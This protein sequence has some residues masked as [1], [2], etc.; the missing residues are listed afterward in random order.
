LLAIVLEECA[1]STS[2]TDPNSA[3]PPT[4]ADAAEPAVD[5]SPDDRVVDPSA[6]VNPDVPDEAAE[7]LPRPPRKSRK[8]LVAI[9]LLAVALAAA[10]GTLAYYLVQLDHAN[11]V[12]KDRDSTIKD[13]QD[14]IDKK[15]TFGAA[16]N[17]L[18]TTASGFNGQPIATVIPL[19]SYTILAKQGW[20][21]RWKGEALDRDIAAV[22]AADSDLKDVFAAAATQ[23]STNATGSTY[24]TVTDQLGAGFVTSYIDDAD[25]LCESDVLA[26]VVSDDALAVHFDA[27][28]VSLPYMTDFLRTGI[29]YHEFA[30]VLQ[31]ANPDQTDIAV[32]SFG[33]DDET[34]ADCFALT[35]LPGWKLNHRIW[36]SSYSYYDVS[37]GYGY[38][39][40]EAQKQVVRNWRDSLA[41]TMPSITQ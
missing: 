33:G 3:T 31:F 18:I 27:A 7:A 29:A 16:M 22:Q 6:G 37:I 25:T 10:G 35:Y 9:V 40:T 32:A 15:E 39:C 38:T 5:V 26:C 4:G 20:A 23:A 1:I 17:D 30:H 11:S 13:Q 24:E 36:V 14:L 21:H 12:I 28:D 41:F 8:A 19:D 2:D 34:M